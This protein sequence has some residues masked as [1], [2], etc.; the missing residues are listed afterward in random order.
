MS[1]IKRHIDELWDFLLKVIENHGW[2]QAVKYAEDQLTEEKK[3]KSKDSNLAFAIRIV[4][5]ELYQKFGSLDKAISIFSKLKESLIP[6]VKFEAIL[7]LS[8]I[9]SQKGDFRTSQA[10]LELLLPK[11]KGSH[12]DLAKI[13]LSVFWRMGF[14]SL[15]QD[16]LK[17][18]KYW[19][20]LHKEATLNLHNSQAANNKIFR[21]IDA[22][23]KDKDSARLHDAYFNSFELYLTD[24]YIVSEQVKYL[25]VS[26]SIF[27][28]MLFDGLLLFRFGQNH[29]ALVQW[30]LCRKLLNWDNIP[31]SAEGISEALQI[32]KACD[33]TSAVMEIMDRIDLPETSFLNWFKQR[34]GKRHYDKVVSEVKLRFENYIGKR[35]YNFLFLANSIDF[36]SVNRNFQNG[37]CLFWE[38]SPTTE[39]KIKQQLAELNIKVV[40]ADDMRYF[41]MPSFE[42]IAHIAKS[43]DYAIIHLTGSKDCMLLLGMLLQTLGKSKIICVVTEKN[44]NIP[45]G[46]PYLFIDENKLHILMSEVNS[47][48]NA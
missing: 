29:D 34:F 37:F 1:E 30:L 18:S 12:I 25:N 38:G 13:P 46:I 31:T 17:S 22:L 33:D 24:G 48:I 10:Y 14:L 41:G 28:P 8:K 19:F 2:Q 11:E 6:E 7:K 26:K 3:I 45:T 15:M 39:A 20:D 5:G 9:Y 36:P 44:N 32:L 43:V 42:I 40:G 27:V 47:L 21:N 23:A 35:D 4:Q 16:D